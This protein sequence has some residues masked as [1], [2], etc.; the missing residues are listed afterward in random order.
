MINQKSL[1]EIK[2]IISEEYFKPTNTPW[3]I[4][5][6][7]GKDSTLLLNLVLGEIVKKDL[8]FL[9]RKTNIL[10]VRGVQVGSK[11]RLKIDPKM[12]SR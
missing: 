7:G 10:K 2:K 9:K 5:Y 8:S 12:K 4:A 11:N 3:I 1:N 6:S